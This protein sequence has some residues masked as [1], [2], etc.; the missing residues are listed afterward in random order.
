LFCRSEINQGLSKRESNL[1]SEILINFLHNILPSQL[2]RMIA[3]DIK[4]IDINSAVE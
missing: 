4:M 2:T 1:L 3:V